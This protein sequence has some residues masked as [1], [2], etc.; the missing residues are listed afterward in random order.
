MSG[1]KVNFNKSEVFCLGG[2]Q[3]KEE[4]YCHILTCRRGTLAMKYLGIPIDKKRIH[5]VDWSPTKNKIE[6]K[7]GCWQGKLLAIGGRLTLINASLAFI[8]DVLL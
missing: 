1:L 2:G 5:N 3:E 8:H 4:M 6:K 7:L